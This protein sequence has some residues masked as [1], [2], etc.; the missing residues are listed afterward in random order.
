M[1]PDATVDENPPSV[2]LFYKGLF[3]L[4]LEANRHERTADIRIVTDMVTALLVFVVAG[5]IFCFEVLVRRA[6][7]V[8][9]HTRRE[10]PPA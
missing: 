2:A 8:C 4:W 1:I 7:P 10:R 6:E 3:D 9:P 5:H